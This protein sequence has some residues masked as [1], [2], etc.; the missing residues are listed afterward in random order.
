MKIAT[1]ICSILFSGI[2]NLTLFI[3]LTP[4]DNGMT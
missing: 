2:S 4:L 3:L 1:V